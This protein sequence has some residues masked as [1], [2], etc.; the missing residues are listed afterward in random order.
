[1]IQLPWLFLASFETS[2]MISPYDRAIAAGPGVWTKELSLWEGEL[3]GASASPEPSLD[4]SCGAFRSGAS[5]TLVM[6]AWS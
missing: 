6:A 2:R 5:T 1:V 3:Y 4:P